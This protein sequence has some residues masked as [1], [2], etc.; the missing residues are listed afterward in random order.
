MP[1]A[2]Q[3]AWADANYSG[4]SATFAAR[5]F[6]A[7]HREHGEPLRWLK[8]L[9]ST[10]NNART[11]SYQRNGSRLGDRGFSYE[12]QTLCADGITLVSDMRVLIESAVEV[13][14]TGAPVVLP[15]GTLNIS[16]LPDKLPFCRN[17][18]IILTARRMRE[19]DLIVR[20]AEGNFDSLPLWPVV[21]VHRVWVGEA[22]NLTLYVQ[23]TDY[24]LV[25]TD[26]NARIEW[27]SGGNKPTSG[28]SYGVE[29][30]RQ[31]QYTFNAGEERHPFPD[32][33]GRLMPLRGTLQLLN[34]LST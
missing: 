10:R 17:D 14:N 22:G 4:S 31:P 3:L 9:L 25:G 8:A 33:T 26:S 24:R 12:E 34:D 5:D 20:S 32:T 1:T 27:L 30:S 2:E 21:A 11:N 28:A 18:R 29:Y 15:H 13:Q 6:E 23:G 19:Q 16:S 7:K